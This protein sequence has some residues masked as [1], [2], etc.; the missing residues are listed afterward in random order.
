MKDYSDSEMIN[1]LILDGGLEVVA[2]DNDTGEL[3]YSFTPKIKEI[4]PDLY[5]EHMH[6]V[7]AE[8]MNLW[9]K[10]FINLDLFQP[11]PLITL[12]LK[13]LD[14]EEVKVLSKQ[15]RWSLFEIV[16]LLQRKV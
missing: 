8:I 4:M 16:R 14:K 6:N 15:E 13:A 2:S 12:T 5:Q 11:D 10:G 1:K 7:N 9:E 3:L